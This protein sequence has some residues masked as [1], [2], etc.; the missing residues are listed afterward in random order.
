MAGTF[1]NCQSL[2]RA[3]ISRN[4]HNGKPNQNIISPKAA[5]NLCACPEPHRHY[6]H[7]HPDEDGIDDEESR[8][9]GLDLCVIIYLVYSDLGHVVESGKKSPRAGNE[10]RLRSAEKGGQWVRNITAGPY[11]FFYYG[12]VAH[13]ENHRVRWLKFRVYRG[14]D[15]T[16]TKK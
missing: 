14:L 15:G 11:L 7:H 5:S 3:E 10:L 4:T 2:A 12:Q 16:V 1:C 8:A 13:R 9:P 6:H